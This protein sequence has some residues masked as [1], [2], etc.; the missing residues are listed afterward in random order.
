MEATMKRIFRRRFFGC[1]SHTRQSGGQNPKLFYD[2]IRPLKHAGRNCQPDLFRRFKINDEFKL[3]CL[4]HRQFSRFGTF[5]YLVHVTSRAP[6]QI[7][8]VGPIGHKTA[9]IDKLLLEV[10]SG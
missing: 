8:V 10:N 3:R 2:P 7:I 5:Q 6:I 4:L 1:Q 9:L